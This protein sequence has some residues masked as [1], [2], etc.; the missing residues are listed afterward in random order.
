MGPSASVTVTLAAEPADVGV[1]DGL[2]RI[3]IAA[4]RAGWE[5]RVEGATDDLRELFGF[6][7]LGELLRFGSGLELRGKPELGEQRCVQVVVDPGDA[8]A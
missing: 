7:G 3:L 6:L 5:V 4:R 8:P 2:L 1:V